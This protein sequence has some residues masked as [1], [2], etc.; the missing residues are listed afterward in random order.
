VTRIGTCT[1]GGDVRVIDPAGREVVVGDA[2]F[3]HFGG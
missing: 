3:D 2:G 1:R